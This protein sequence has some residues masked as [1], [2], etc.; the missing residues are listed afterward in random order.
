MPEPNAAP[1]EIARNVAL[2]GNVSLISIFD[3]IQV[4]EN[5]KLSGLLNLKSDARIGAV[6]FNVGQIVDAETEG[7]TGTN[8]FRKIVEITSGTFEFTVSDKEFPVVIQTPSNT[9]LILDT[10]KDIDEESIDV[11]SF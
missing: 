1:T 5:S 7:F 8:A 11:D 2:A 4:I 6:L 3:A 10:L 9:N